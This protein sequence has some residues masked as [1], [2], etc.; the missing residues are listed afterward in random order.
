M[1]QASR[2]RLTAVR[3]MRASELERYFSTIRGE[4][5]AL[6]AGDSTL[7]ALDRFQASWRSLPIASTAPALEEHYRTHGFPGTWFPTDPR[8]RWLQNLF[9]ATNPHPEGAKDLLVTPRNGGLYG[10]EHAVFHPTFHR[11]ATAF[12]FY[13]LFLIDR[14][15]GRLLYSVMKEIDLGM[16]LASD[17]YRQTPLGRV[18]QKAISQP[19]GEVVFEDYAPYVPSKLAPAAFAAASIRRAGAVTG[20][21]AIQVA[22][23]EINE[24]MD[25][26]RRWR[27]QGLGGS[28]QA[29]AIGSDGTLRSDRRES[30]ENPEGYLEGLRKAGLP[31]ETVEKVRRNGTGVLAYPVS[32]GGDE[33]LR[34]SGPLRIGDLK[35]DIVAEIDKAEALEPV[36]SLR[37]RILLIGFAVAAIFFA[38]AGVIGRSVTKPVLA[39][40]AVTRRIGEGERGLRILSSSNDEIGQ[41]AADFNRMSDALEKTTVSKQE[42]EV[43]AGRLLTAQEDERKRVARELHDDFSQRLAA[44]AIEIGRLERLPE[45]EEIRARLAQL[46][47]D[48]A[49]ISDQ[50]HTLS[51]SLHPAMLDDLGLAAAIEAECRATFER[52]GPIIEFH[53]DGPLSRVPRATQVVLYR[54]AQEAL[55]NIQ[56]HADVAEA[57]VSIIALPDSVMLEVQDYGRGFD[58]SSPDWH[59]GIGLASMEERA[60]LAGG[61]LTVASQPGKGTLIRAALPLRKAEAS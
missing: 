48:M 16:P 8:T 47:Q 27:E 57:E 18:Y 23:D 59:P 61:T 19:D 50:V 15:E 32:P 11:F 13:D 44:A 38:A 55:R 14:D 4:V 33:V 30:I 17:P 10:E 28:G 2:D 34:S 1:E 20:V 35:W 36:A 37:R 45:S 60:R 56:R 43:L 21:L 9:I 53:A 39:L 58:R 24:V 5:S 29:Y 31:E 42:L 51:R 46:K 49:D 3:E 40:A 54:I 22:I 26:G 52:G 41:L 12:G 7:R 25:G 6:A